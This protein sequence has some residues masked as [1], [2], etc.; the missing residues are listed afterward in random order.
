[1]GFVMRAGLFFLAAGALVS[2]ARAGHLA[3]GM[4]ILTRVPAQVRSSPSS[5]ASL[6]GTQP[7]GTP[8]T[9]A[10]GPVSADGIL[11]WQINYVLGAD[12]WSDER[13]L[14]EAYF[15]APESAGGWRALVTLDSTPSS[16]QKAV[17]REK[18]GLDW[19]KLKLAR[20]YSNALSNG[21]A[22]LVIRNGWIA[23]EW[24]TS[25]TV[26]VASVTK[27]LTGLSL[28]KLFDLSNA[29]LTATPINPESLVYQ[30]LPPQF[31]DSDPLKRQIR[32]NT[33]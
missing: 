26:T 19:D 9:I 6:T 22:V 29:G 3:Q 16:A 15:P 5:Q 14:V 1:M 8:G 10:N 2:P 30:Y 17:I 11:W 28:A 23:G 32:I 7:A 31:G 12:G 27:S 4:Q 13:A 33:S 18:A 21:S 24:G 20:D 25:S